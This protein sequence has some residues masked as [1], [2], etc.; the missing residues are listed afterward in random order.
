MKTET[1]VHKI[2]PPRRKWHLDD[3]KAVDVS[4]PGSGEEGINPPRF[5]PPEKPPLDGRRDIG[6]PIVLPSRGR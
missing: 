4:S 2:T 6:D 1:P 3:F 5:L